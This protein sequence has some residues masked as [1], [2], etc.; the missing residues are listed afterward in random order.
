MR[1]LG[2]ALVFV[3][4]ASLA[5]GAQGLASLDEVRTLR[6]AGE[7]GDAREKAE[8]VLRSDVDPAEAIAARLELA[9]IHDRVGLHHNTRPVAEALQNIDA[10]SELLRPGDS[11]SAAAIQLAY[12]DYYYR[13]E[14]DD[15]LFTRATGYVD[16]AVKMFREVGDTR[17]EADAVHRRGL[18]HL[19]KRE[20]DEA[21]DLFDESLR[22][23]EIDG[24]VSGFKVSMGD[25]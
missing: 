7:L 21:R 3:T 18:I 20:L 2:V 8:Q 6:L 17:G 11:K 19:Q 5:G 16:T 24:V 23:D 15:R 22:L 10:A 14:M 4:A 13:A 25:I 1:L 12:G 9:K